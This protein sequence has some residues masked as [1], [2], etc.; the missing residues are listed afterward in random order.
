VQGYEGARVHGVQG[1]KGPVDA[2]RSDDGGANDARAAVRGNEEGTLLYIDVQPG[3]SRPGR[4]SYDQW[5]KRFRLS[6][7]A[8]AED[9]R[10]NEE[11]ILRLGELL[12][13]APGSLRLT[14][15]RTDRQKTVLVTGMVPD[16]VLG[17]LVPHLKDGSLPAG[18]AGQKGGSGP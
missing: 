15:G 7:G 9:G 8:R 4:L 18:R 6:V 14:S 13:L 3:S 2:Q 5:R 17:K 10:A 11:A 12:E 1:G 16:Q